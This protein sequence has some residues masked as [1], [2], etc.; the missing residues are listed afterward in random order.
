M[1]RKNKAVGNKNKQTL[2]GT[3]NVSQH[4]CVERYALRT[5]ME[6][7][8]PDKLRDKRTQITEEEARKRIINEVRQSKL[9]NFRQSNELRIFKGNMYIVERSKNGNSFNVVTILLSKVTQRE[10]FAD[11]FDGE[12]QH[13]RFG[14][15][16]TNRVV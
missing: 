4:C 12:I 15:K 5:G 3:I 9:L 10:L 2:F 14:W 16:N 13:N 11:K 8:S 1:A 6:L 7:V